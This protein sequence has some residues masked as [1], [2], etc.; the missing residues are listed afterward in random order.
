MVTLDTN[1]FIRLF[2]EEE[3]LQAKK[4]EALLNKGMELFVPWK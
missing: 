2:A 3:S 4:V 1:L